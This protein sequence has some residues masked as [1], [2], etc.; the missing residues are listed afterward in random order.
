MYAYSSLLDR[1]AP[2]DSSSRRLEMEISR[3]KDIP[4]KQRT[5]VIPYKT[6]VQERKKKDIL[7]SF[8]RPKWPIRR[9]KRLHL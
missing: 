7:R 6:G 2:L 3:Y 4:P 5:S 9:N 1:D 8:K